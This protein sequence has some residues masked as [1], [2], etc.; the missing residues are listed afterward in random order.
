MEKFVK[1]VNRYWENL[2]SK[3]VVDKVMSTKPYKSIG[4]WK[5]CPTLYQI[6]AY[7]D[8]DGSLSERKRKRIDNHIEDCRACSRSVGELKRVYEEA[9]KNP[10]PSEYF[11]KYMSQLRRIMR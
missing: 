11:E 10:V 3:E 4:I 2:S 1:D 7:L 5:D 6:F 9:Q 8:I